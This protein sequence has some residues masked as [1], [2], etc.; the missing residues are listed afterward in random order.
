MATVDLSNQLPVHCYLFQILFTVSVRGGPDALPCSYADDTRSYEEITKPFITIEING[1][2]IGCRNSD[3]QG[4]LHS[5]QGRPRDAQR[6]P[7]DLTGTSKD[8]KMPPVSSRHRP[9]TSQQPPSEPEV[10]PQGTPRYPQRYPQKTS[11]LNLYL[12]YP[13]ARFQPGGMQGPIK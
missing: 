10:P 12:M 5:A 4:R 1:K 3:F 7:R 13:T 2:A 9:G 11:S 8:S 6:P